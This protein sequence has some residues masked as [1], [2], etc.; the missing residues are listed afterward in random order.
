MWEPSTF[1]FLLISFMKLNFMAVPT[2]IF[3]LSCMNLKEK[4]KK[5]LFRILIVKILEVTT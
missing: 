5:A 1:S 4:E 2:G 3:L